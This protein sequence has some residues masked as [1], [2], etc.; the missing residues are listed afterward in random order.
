MILFR[1][2]GFNYLLHLQ[3]QGFHLNR[4]GLLVLPLDKDQIAQMMG[5]T[6]P[7]TNVLVLEVGA[8]SIMNG[9]T[10][11]SREDPNLIQRLV[12]SLGMDR[13]LGQQTGAGHM[14]PPQ[15]FLHS[16]AGFIEMSRFLTR[17]QFFPNGF[18][19]W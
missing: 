13:I 11:E 4:P 10:F 15:L 18:H 9:C 1:L 7:M 12:A 2:G 17:F 16:A 8:V 14:Q 6:Q 19:D 5:I 3:K